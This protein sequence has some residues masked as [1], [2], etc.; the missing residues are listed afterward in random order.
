MAIK[1][2]TVPTNKFMREHYIKCRKGVLLLFFFFLI[3]SQLPYAWSSDDCKYSS[4]RA[5]DKERQFL[6]DKK[7]EFFAPKEWVLKRGKKGGVSTVHF[8]SKPPCSIEFL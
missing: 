2:Q 4:Y 3:F 8:F 5:L 7:V 6:G 1:K